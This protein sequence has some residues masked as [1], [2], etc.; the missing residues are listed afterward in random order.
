MRIDKWIWAVRMV[1]TRSK[2]TDHCKLGRVKLNGKVVKPAKMIA[3]GDIIELSTPNITQMYKVLGFVAKQAS[4][5]RVVGFF[6]D[7]T[8]EPEEIVKI[9]KEAGELRKADKKEY[10][11]RKYRKDQGKLTK[12]ERR[13]YESFFAKM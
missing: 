12:R 4:A 3:V 13:K 6:E 11:K 1:K 2:A 10:E 8:P 9:S 7:I 5:E